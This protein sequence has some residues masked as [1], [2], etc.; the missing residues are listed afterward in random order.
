ML[1]NLNYDTKTVT[2]LS[3]P[4]DT[5]VAYSSNTA[6]KINALYQIGKNQNQGVNL[7]AKK[8]SEI[9]GQSIHHFLIIDFNGFKSVVDAL[10]G[11][12]VDVPQRIYDREYPNN[13]W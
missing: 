1:A 8:V 5:Y 4:R 2:L 9:T 6:G 13:N 12:E 10:G 11:V 3:I 7:L